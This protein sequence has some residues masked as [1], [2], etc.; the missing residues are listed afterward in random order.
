MK[1]VSQDIA[2]G[3]FARGLVAMDS[4]NPPTG[5]DRRLFLEGARARLKHYVAIGD[6]LYAAV[7]RE[8]IARLEALD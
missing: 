2:S 6:K 5:E 1:K 8:A 3:Q 4:S 7:E